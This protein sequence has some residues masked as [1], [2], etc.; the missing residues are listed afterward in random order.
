MKNQKVNKA[1]YLDFTGNN[2]AEFT[3]SIPFLV[4]SIHVKSA[5]LT[6]ITAVTSGSEMYYT[7]V[8]DLT[9]QEPMAQIFNNSVYSASQF[10]DVTYVPHAPIYVN[11]TYKFTLFNTSGG[12]I[13]ASLLDCYVAMIIEFND[14][15]SMEH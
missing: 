10:S 3:L 14:V 2:P 13:S 1:I 6:T 11:G 5:C 8:S 15:G 12:A 4:E 9:N 7:L